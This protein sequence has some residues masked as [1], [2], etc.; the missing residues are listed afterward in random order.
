MK[1]LYL[2]SMG[3]LAMATLRCTSP[4]DK[5]QPAAQDSF[6]YKVEQFADLRIMRYRVPGFEELSLKQKELVYYLSQA[7]NCGRDILFDQNGK[8][9]LTIR[10]TLENIYETYSGDRTSEAYKQ[11][12][13]YLKRVWFSNGIY[14]HYASDK[15][16]PGFDAAQFSELVSKSEATKFP[17]AKGE[18]VDQLVARISPVMFDPAVMPKKVSKDS[19]KDL[20]LNSAANFYDQIT[21]AEAEAF[22]NKMRKADEAEPVSYGLNSK[23]V[24]SNGT[25]SERVYKIDGLYG[26]AIEKIVFWLE[27]AAMV[28]EN[29]HQKKSIESLISYY[30]TGDLKTWDEYNILWVQDTSRVD[31]VNGFIESYEDPLGMKAT[32]ESVVNFRDEVATRRTII[33]S[34]NAQWFENHSPV[35]P[36][37]RK[38]EVKGV[39]A[40]VITAAQLAGDCYPSTPIGINLPN[41]NWIRKEHGSKSVTIENITYAYDQAAIGNG[42]MEEFYAS[43]QEID[44]DKKYGSLADN[45]HTDLHE[46]LGHGS[47]QLLPGVSSE[48]LKNYSSTIE[49]ARADLFA[50]YYIADPKM[51]ELGILPDAEA[52]KAEYDNFMRNGLMTQLVRVEAGKNI[53][54]DHMR[55]RQLIA[56][57]VYE[58]GKAANVVAFV[59]RDNKTYVQINDYAQLRVLFGELLSEI[60]RVKSE[61]DY[62]GAKK[63]VEDFGVKVNHTLHNEVLARYKKLNLAP[64]GGFVNPVYELVEKDGKVVD[65]RVT[66]T[67]GYAEQM[68]RYSKNFS[69]LPNEN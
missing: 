61:G 5:Q 34:Q 69:F 54:E 9:N 8:Y 56:Q 38:K 11:F 21:E 2:A 17:V 41:A 37:F 20:I 67:E 15:I 42:F 23:L 13:I 60:Q 22:Y 33:I 12:E 36:R 48:A 66:Y 10:R 31:F 63:L 35:D 16:M 45:V 39:S 29:E 32:W 1:L 57:W 68:L 18:T 52:F 6:S 26:P 65:V 51:V 59:T 62:A 43:Q 25:I 58:K 27:K 24:K 7:A 14:H 64:Y 4:V 49:E 28:A 46:C 50:L 55:N 30:K 3:I 40:K 19:S 44:R 47:G 53:E